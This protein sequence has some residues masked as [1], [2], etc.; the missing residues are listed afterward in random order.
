MLALH[1]FHRRHPEQQIHLFG[2]PTVAVDFPVT[3]HGRLTT[4]KLAELYNT[5]RAG[6]AMSF[7]NVSLVPAEMIAC[8]VVPVLSGGPYASADLESPYARW[9]DPTPGALADMLSEVVRS[10]SP[11]PSEIA[12]SVST[13]GWAPGQRVAV[14]TIERAVYGS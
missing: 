6:I 12:G 3:N 2:D 4:A 1:E 5:A 9:A 7:T 14:E 10:D 11:K 8:G 13:E